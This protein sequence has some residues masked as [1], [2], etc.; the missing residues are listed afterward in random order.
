MDDWMPTLLNP[1]LAGLTALFGTRLAAQPT[2][3]GFG[4]AVFGASLLAAVATLV[5][6]L[7][8]KHRGRPAAFVP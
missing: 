8:T 7:I 6:N 2:P 5:W 1:I 4:P 3:L